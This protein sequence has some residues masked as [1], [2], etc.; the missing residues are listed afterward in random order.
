MLIIN[1]TYN[2]TASINDATIW[3]RASCKSLRITARRRSVSL[4]VVSDIRRLVNALSVSNVLLVISSLR[5]VVSARI[6]SYRVMRS[7]YQ[8]SE[9][10]LWLRLNCGVLIFQ[11]ISRRRHDPA[12]KPASVELIIEGG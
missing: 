4:S 1:P 12:E 5:I 11:K 6:G 7:F 10:D 8:C 3:R 9:G 2:P